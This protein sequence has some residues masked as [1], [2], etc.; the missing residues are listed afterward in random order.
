MGGNTVYMPVLKAKAGELTALRHANQ[1][2][3]TPLIEVPVPDGRKTLEDALKKVAADLR[4]AWDH[5][6][7]VDALPFIRAAGEVLPS[8][9]H[10]LDFL[11]A[12]LTKLGSTLIPVTGIGRATTFQAAVNRVATA[13]GR[14]AALRLQGSDLDRPT[15]LLGYAQATAVDIG[16]T[17]SQIDVIVDVEALTMPT[18]PGRITAVTTVLTALTSD[19][20]RSYFVVA[21]GYPGNPTGVAIGS[22]TSLQRADWSFWLAGRSGFPVQTTYG[23][24]GVDTP[25]FAASGGRAYSNIKYTTASQWLFIRGEN[26][27]A[28]RG[29]TIFNDNC[30]ILVPRPEFSGATFSFGDGF[31]DAKAAAGATSGNPTQWRTAMYSHHI[32][33]VLD[34][35]TG[36]GAPH[37]VRRGPPATSPVAAT[38]PTVKKSR[39]P[40]S[41][42]SKS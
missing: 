30:R 8:G 41:R 26:V 37:P 40:S 5:E 31:F 22:A 11:N 15:T 28:P 38:K 23:D 25:S 9:T 32:A 21:G 4:A 18:L 27:T 39:A 2:L 29:F 10:V 16:L 34:Q 33:I 12:E 19:R 24:Y 17:P 13:N 7:H 3:L 20:W 42:K 6:I 1:S 14:G 36:L 35:L